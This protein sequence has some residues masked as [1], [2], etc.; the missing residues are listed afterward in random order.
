MPGAARQSQDEAGGTII[1]GSADVIINGTGA[2]RVGDAVAGHGLPP[3]DSPV[4]VQG[5]DTVFVN[6]IAL[7]RS[8][9]LASCGDAATGSSDV[10][11]G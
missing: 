6:G 8:G 9:D 7:S 10:I 3:H 1:E 4:L 11:V 2:A 5:S